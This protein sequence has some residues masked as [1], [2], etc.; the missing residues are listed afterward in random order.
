MTNPI[1]TG[2]F[3]DREDDELWIQFKFERLPNFY[4][5]CGMIDHVTGRCNFGNPTTLTS[6]Y[7]VSAWIYGL[8]LKAEVA[9]NLNF[10]NTP[11]GKEDRQSFP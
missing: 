1:Q 5:Q 9:E 6:S 7:C 10:V 3:V 11:E 4:F 8:W 2:S